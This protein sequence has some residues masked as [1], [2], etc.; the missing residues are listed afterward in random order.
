MPSPSFSFA[1]VNAAKD[2]VAS[3]KLEPTY[4]LFS[5]QLGVAYHF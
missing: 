4:N 2:T 1:G 3:F 5:S